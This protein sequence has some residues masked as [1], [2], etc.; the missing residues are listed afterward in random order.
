MSEES[1]SSLAILHIHKHKDADID[2]VL[3]EFARLKGRI[4]AF[5]L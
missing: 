4:L 3:S 1:L 2:N 5:C